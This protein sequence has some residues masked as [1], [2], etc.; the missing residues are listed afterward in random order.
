MPKNGPT[1]DDEIKD[2]ENNGKERNAILS[3]LFYSKIGKVISL[4]FAKDI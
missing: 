4:K 1:S 2:Y 3:G